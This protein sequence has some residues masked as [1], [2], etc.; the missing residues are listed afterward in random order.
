MFN[1]TLS[2]VLSIRPSVTRCAGISVKAIHRL[3][4]LFGYLICWYL[5]CEGQRRGFQCRCYKSFLLLPSP[6]NN[7]INHQALL[8]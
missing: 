2:R 7:T 4:C 1:Y 6:F 5:G 8:R 3:E